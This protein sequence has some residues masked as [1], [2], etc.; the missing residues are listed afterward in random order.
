MVAQE[1]QENDF[2]FPNLT[3]WK[4]VFQNCASLVEIDFTA[5]DRSESGFEFADNMFD[6]C[7]AL[8]TAKLGYVSYIGTEA[9]K[10]C[11]SLASFEATP[12]NDSGE[13][14]EN[15]ATG[16]YLGANGKQPINIT[17]EELADAEA[18][19]AN[20]RSGMYDSYGWNAWEL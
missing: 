4:S 9:F 16:F 19:A 11:S 3:V 6:G 17:L 14:Y 12:T 20:I 5:W 1:A 15:T 10:G 13:Y 2:S 8:T 7:S 18:M